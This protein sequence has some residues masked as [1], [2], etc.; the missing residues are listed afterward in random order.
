MTD[1][2][3]FH[4]GP[5]GCLLIHGFTGGPDEI[6]GLGEH[7]AS[8]GHT[9]LGLRLPGHH[10]PPDDLASVRW[11]DWLAAVSDGLASLRARCATVSLVG[12]SLGGAL[13][14]LAAADQH[15]DRLALIATPMYLH[16]GWPVHTLALGRHVMPWYY[17]LAKASF[18]DPELRAQIMRRAPDAD[19]D[20]P[21]VQSRLRGEVRI[22]IAALDELRMALIHARRAL[23]RVRA[24]ILVMHGRADEVA[25]LSSPQIILRGVAS[26]R[27]ELVWWDGT[28]HQLLIHGPHRQAIYR[29]VETFLAM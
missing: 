21:Q 4:G 18:A 16:G 13:A 14:L 12:F 5:S 23:R 28:G 22:S 27:R 2:F 29:R 3:F 8:A 6:Q 17:P 26:P 1:P 24:P 25:P 19:I 11:A 7:L 10:G 20:D 15:V 9:V